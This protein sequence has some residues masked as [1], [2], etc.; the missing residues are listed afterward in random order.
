[1][2]LYTLYLNTKTTSGILAPTN[3]SN[4]N[5]VYFSVPWES[6]FSTS[7]NAKRYLNNNAKCRIKAQLVSA[8]AV[9]ITWANQK[10][11]LRIGGMVS[12]SQNPTNGVILG[13]VKPVI[14]PTLNTQWYLECDT[15][16]T[17][18][19]EISIPTN[20]NICI[21]LY[22]DAGIAM[23]NALEYEVTLHFEIEDDATESDFI[24]NHNTYSH[25]AVI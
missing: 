11:T 21:G 1:M 15:T 7:M 2:R 22:N 3:K 24:N 6:V 12:S 14:N 18:G 23:T 25:M 5:C 16:Q 8:A 10:G 4:L 13:V 20:S 19:I 9:G 17:A